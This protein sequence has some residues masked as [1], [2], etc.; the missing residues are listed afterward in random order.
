MFL[1]WSKRTGLS[2]H[3]LELNCQMFSSKIP[4]VMDLKFEM[5]DY[6]NMMA[7]LNVLLKQKVA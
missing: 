4:I 5:P 1:W 6:Q 3:P 2:V 7:K